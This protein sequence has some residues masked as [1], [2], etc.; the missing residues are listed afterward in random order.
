MSN[1]RNRIGL[2]VPA[3]Y[4]FA[5]IKIWAELTGTTTANVALVLMQRGLREALKDKEVPAE[6][7]SAVHSKFFSKL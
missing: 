1:K 7:I 4:D 2:S 3:D 6:I 5:L